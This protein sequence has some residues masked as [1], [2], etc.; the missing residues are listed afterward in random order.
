MET[1]ESWRCCAIEEKPALK[2]GTDCQ[3]QDPPNK[4]FWFS[5]R[6][7]LSTWRKKTVPGL[8]PFQGKSDFRDFSQPQMIY[9]A[10]TVTAM[11]T[12]NYVNKSGMINSHV[13][14]DKTGVCT[15]SKLKRVLCRLMFSLH[16]YL[17]LGLQLKP[18]LHLSN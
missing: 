1:A 14:A 13:G 15:F 11:P 6:N 7:Y 12:K 18:W 3:G 16:F 8:D 5:T 10:L 4:L 2:R 17:L 9:E